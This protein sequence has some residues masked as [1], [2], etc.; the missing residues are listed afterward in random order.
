MHSTVFARFKL[1][2]WCFYSYIFHLFF[3][4]LLTTLLYSPRWRSL[5]FQTVVNINRVS[6]VQK[7][8]T[9]FF[10]FFFYSALEHEDLQHCWDRSSV[11]FFFGGEESIFGDRSSLSF[12][13]NFSP[14]NFLVLNL[15]ELTGRLEM[16]S[17]ARPCVREIDGAIVWRIA[18][19]T[20][21]LLTEREGELTVAQLDSKL[22]TVQLFLR[23]LANY[24]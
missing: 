9:C 14:A 17:L 15:I 10:F 7:P 19:E 6:L 8:W 20:S 4:F 3:F 16:I 18:I 5:F 21:F 23:A 11:L 2:F 1:S 24:P 12:Y 13:A 22:L